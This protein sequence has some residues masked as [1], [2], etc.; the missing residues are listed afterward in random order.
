M[1]RMSETKPCPECERF[2]PITA[3]ACRCGWKSTKGM[4]SYV[5]CA[6]AG[7]GVSATLRA[8]TKTGWANVCLEH[9]VQIVQKGAD[10]LC[11]SLG[12]DTVKKKRDYVYDILKG[13]RRK[14]TPDYQPKSV[15]REEDEIPF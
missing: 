2:L 11:R 3:V 12:L 8:K 1:S 10:E 9:D 14:H 7:C 15:Q 6:F 4:D 5:A 13:M